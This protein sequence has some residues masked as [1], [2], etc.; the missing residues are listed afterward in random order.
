MKK[1]YPNKNFGLHV[2]VNT[3]TRSVNNYKLIAKYTANIIKKYELIPSFIDIGGGFFGGVPEKPT[4]K[5]YISAIKEELEN[6]VQT[7]KTVLIIEPGSAFCGSAFDFY[8]SVID[9]KETLKSKIVT[10][11]GSRIN[12]DPLWIKNRYLYSIYDENGKDL[13]NRPIKDKQIVCGYTCM[14]HDRLMILKNSQ[15]LRENDL[16]VYHK[17]GNYTVTFGGMFI[18]Y[19]PDVYVRKINGEIEQVRNRISVNEFYKIHQTL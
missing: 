1:I 4:A 2:H 15:E 18:R 5:E 12:I 14:D 17:V 7:D 11:N 13:S 19:Y 16:I 10:T 8:T 9:T 3:V 6:A